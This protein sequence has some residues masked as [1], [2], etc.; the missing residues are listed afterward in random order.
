MKKVFLSLGAIAIGFGLAFLAAGLSS[1]FFVLLPAVAFVF[2]YFSSWRWG[3][4][5][6][7]LLFAGYTFTISLMWLGIDNINLSY[8]IPYI[9]AFLAGGFSMLLI[10]ALAPQLRK[11]AKRAGS[12]TALAVLVIFTGWA[13]YTAVP[14][15]SYYYQVAVLSS[16]NVNNL[17]LYLPV[18]TVSGEPYVEL[19]DQVLDM[20]GDLTRNFTQELVDTEQGK[21]IKVTIPQLE[22]TNDKVPV[23]R[24]HANIIFWYG[25]GFW[26]KI[27]PFELIQLMP[28]SDVVQVNTVTSQRFLGPVK[29][30]ESKVIERFNVPV[31]ASASTQA[32]IKLTMWNRTDRGEAVN[33]TC[34]Y[35]KLDPYTERIDCNIQTDG[36]WKSVPV[37][38]ASVM[39]IRGISD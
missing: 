26:Q 32:Q 13:G 4:L 15:Y 21:M 36:E 17:E 29:S 23:P 38:A 31:K 19:Y 9:G 22:K 3:L 5:C 20:P 8:P 33:F 37:E 35:S 30:R 16:E 6:G 2:G 11:G 1:F 7:L 14:H 18:G 10:G 12:I 34:T 25:R 28:R 27:V 24:Y 39:E